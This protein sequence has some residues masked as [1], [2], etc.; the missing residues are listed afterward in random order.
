MLS[1]NRRRT[2][3]DPP[4]GERISWP[5]TFT[6]HY[7]GPRIFLS[8]LVSF[9]LWFAWTSARHHIWIQVA[10]G[11]AATALVCASFRYV[12]RGLHDLWLCGDT[13][14]FTRRHERVDVPIDRVTGVDVSVRASFTRTIAIYWKD[15]VGIERR[16]RFAVKDP[17]PSWRVLFLRL[18]DRVRAAHGHISAD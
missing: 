7:V 18:V 16:V 11:L 9:T 10:E 2:K 4:A 13:L 14:T 12:G 3:L 6:Y 1:P 8:V 17:S 5:L 15:D